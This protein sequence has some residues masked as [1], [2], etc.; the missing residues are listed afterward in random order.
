MTKLLSFM[1]ENEKKVFYNNYLV[2]RLFIRHLHHI[3]TTLNIIHKYQ[4]MLFIST[5]RK[6]ISEGKPLNRRTE[7][8]TAV[9][10]VEGSSPTLDQHSGS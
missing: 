7:R 2:Y 5:S 6:F 10:E 4:Q 1:Y 3:T 8:R 9:R